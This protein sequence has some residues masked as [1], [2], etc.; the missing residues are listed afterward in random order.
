MNHTRKHPL[1]ALLVVAAALFAGPMARA[2]VVTDWNI[3]AGEIVVDARLGPPPANRVLAIVQTA[4]YEAANAITKRYPASGLKL[5][6]A[7]GASVD[8]A[9]AAANRRH[10]GEARA[11]ATGGHRHCLSGCVGEDRRRPGEDRRASQSENRPRRRSSRCAPMTAPP[12]RR[13]TGLTPPRASTCRRS[14][15]RSRSGRSASRG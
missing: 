11:V 5:E 2:D 13:R 12:R 1:R 7:P 14:S 6:A 15:R 10:A 3:K 8:A 4:V 9:V